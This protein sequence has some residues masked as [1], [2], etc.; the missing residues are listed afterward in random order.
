VL[1]PKVCL[2]AATGK[3]LVIIIIKWFIASKFFQVRVGYINC[4]DN[5]FTTA[6]LEFLINAGRTVAVDGQAT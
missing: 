6:L 5:Q 4:S 2:P 3:M 1:P